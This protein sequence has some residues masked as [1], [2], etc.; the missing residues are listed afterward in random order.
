MN[1]RLR[2]TCEELHTGSKLA[3]VACGTSETVFVPA[4]MAGA[5][6]PAAVPAIM[7]R[8]PIMICSPSMFSPRPVL[9]PG[10]AR[11]RFPKLIERA[12][13]NQRFEFVR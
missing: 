2:D 8:R 6:S 3:S 7:P 12:H 9:A 4:A 1:P 5:A 10:L 13:S 11:P